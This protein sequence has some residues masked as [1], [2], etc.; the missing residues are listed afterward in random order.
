MDGIK[1]KDRKYI[2]GTYGRYDLHIVRG[3]GAECEDEKGKKYIDLGSGIGVNCLGWCDAG[4]IKA[5]EGKTA[6]HFQPLLFRAGRATGGG[7][8]HAHGL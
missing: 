3:S 4:W 8:L 6:T 7:A 1:D 2:A 5:V